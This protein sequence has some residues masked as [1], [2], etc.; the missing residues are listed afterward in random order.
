[1]LC[2]KR[3]DRLVMPVRLKLKALV[4]NRL[5]HGDHSALEFWSQKFHYL[6]VVRPSFSWWWHHHHRQVLVCRC[7]LLSTWKITYFLGHFVHSFWVLVEITTE[8]SCCFWNCNRTSVCNVCNTGVHTP[9][10]ASG[11]L[12]KMVWLIVVNFGSDYKVWEIS[13]ISLVQ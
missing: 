5:S 7:V 12:E 11:K 3:R 6:T 9:Q 2:C 4:K 1:M 8:S 10:Y 13:Q